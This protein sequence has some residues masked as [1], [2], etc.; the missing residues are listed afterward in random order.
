MAQLKFGNG[1]KDPSRFDYFR[2]YYHLFIEQLCYS[3]SPK[4]NRITTQNIVLQLLSISY[5]L[6]LVQ[7]YLSIY[8][9]WRTK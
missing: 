3:H 5:I 6:H 2:I 8:K 1:A 9:S 7:V 4:Q